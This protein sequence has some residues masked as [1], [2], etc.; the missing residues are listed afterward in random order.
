MQ[1]KKVAGKT[2]IHYSKYIQRFQCKGKTILFFPIQINN[3]K[4][5]SNNFII[6][7][8]LYDFSG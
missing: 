2:A 1:P 8:L 6:N 5:L 4:L 7:S 3:E